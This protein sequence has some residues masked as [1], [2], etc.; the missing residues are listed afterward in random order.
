LIA[1][2]SIY[3]KTGDAAKARP[4]LIAASTLHPDNDRTLFALGKAHF[5]LGDFQNALNCFLKLEDKAIDDADINYHIAM[6]YGRLN[7]PGES[8][9]YFGLHFK[10]EKKSES[11]LF[12]FRKAQAFFPEGSK[13]ADLVS[14]AIKELDSGAGRKPATKTGR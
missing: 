13:K 9:Y 10:N 3:L 6:S 11:A 14:A 7:Q 8:H 4:L 5:A 1:A 2:G 12:H